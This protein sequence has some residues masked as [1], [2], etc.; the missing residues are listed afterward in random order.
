MTEPL[1]PHPAA[2]T[3]LPGQPHAPTAA[4]PAPYPPTPLAPC[5]VSDPLGALRVLR[6]ARFAVG[7]ITLG[8]IALLGRVVQLQTCPPAPIAKLIDSQASTASIP[9]R[10]GSLLDRHGRVL[11]TTH[12]A[13][14]LYVDP[15]LIT[16]PGTFSERLGHALGYDPAWIEKK[17][18]QR[19]GSRYVVLEDR[20]SDTKLAALSSL[21]LPGVATEPILVRD[22]PHGPLAGQVIGFVGAEGK[23]LEGLEW[24]TD[25]CLAGQPGQVRRIRDARR[26]TLWIDPAGYQ[27]P[28][29]GQPIQLSLDAVIQHIA[30][31]ELQKACEQFNAPSGQLIVMDPQTG[32]ILAM[33][34]YPWFDPNSFAR[35]KPEQRRNRCVSD[36]F[37][38]GS[39]FKPFVWSVA[40]QLGL[41]QPNEV[42]DCT[43][44]GTYV[45]PEGRRLHDMHAHGLITWDQVL[46]K[47]SNIG[48]AI[49]A[50][51][52]G[53]QRLH[54]ALC[55][56]G[57]GATTGSRLPGESPGLVTPL[58][59]WT[60][61]SVTSVPMGQEVAVTPLQ[62][63]T[64]FAVFANDGFRVTPTIARRTLNPRVAPHVATPIFEQIIT[65]ATAAYTRAVLRRVV[66]EGTGRRADSPLYPIFGK[67]G[68]AQVADRTHGGYLPDQYVSSFVGGAPVDAPRL[69]VACVVH[70]PEKSKG[71]QGGT[72]AAPAVRAVVEQTLQYLGVPPQQPDDLT[73]PRLV[74][75]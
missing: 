55:A 52:M 66:T 65:P 21:D 53:P 63:A 68:T 62:L 28:V 1:A 40:T 19:P 46:I 13:Q 56:F 37:E 48:M 67:T 58:K 74:Q 10:R 25:P 31:T 41:A 43:T 27:P 14:R 38:P 36:V 75:R 5:S 20:L 61:Y 49:V 33:A 51:R 64:A 7:L 59:Q 17:L 69:V 23:G 71:Y 12:V 16:D 70:Q 4:T 8:L 32:E 9:G 35:S 42:I 6:V 44:S 22:Y 73:A 18:S 47:S 26:Q 29:D 39:T 54:G 57:F 24:T 60:H 72:V 50:Q 34:N 45:T 3:S 2:P 30:E 11:A 15:A